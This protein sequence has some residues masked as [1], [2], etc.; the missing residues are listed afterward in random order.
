[1]IHLLVIAAS[2]AVVAKAAASIVTFALAD[3]HD[4]KRSKQEIAALD[5]NVEP[6][7]PNWFV[8]VLARA[9]DDYQMLVRTYIDPILAGR[10][11]NQ[12]LQELVGDKKRNLS[13]QEKRS[14]RRL[15]LGFVAFGL[16]VDVYFTGIQLLPMVVVIGIYN[17]WPW[18]KESYR[19]AFKE[20]RFG[21]IHLI[22]LY[23]A[24]MWI[25]GFFLIGVV[26]AI[27]SGLCQKIQMIT[28]IG[29]REDLIDVLGQKP[30]HVWIE[31][32]GVEVEIP[33]EQLQL[34]DTLILDVGQ[35]IPVDGMILD[36][37]AL[38]DQQR[39]TGESQPVEKSSGDTVLAA[40]VVLGGKL[41]VCVE[42]SGDDT[43]AAKIA[44]V[45]NRTVEYGVDNLRSEFDSVEHTVW[46]MLA[47]GMF[48]LLVG[49][50]VTGAAIL[51]CNYVVGIIPL[52]MIT[53]L[54][55]LSAGSEHGVYPAEL[56][57]WR[58][59]ATMALAEPEEARASPQVTRA[60]KKRIKELER[61]LLRKDRALAET[62]A[63]LVLSKKVAAI[64]NKGEVE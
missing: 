9:D 38:V 37:W 60:D 36:G 6:V 45:L 29:A 50:P 14:N 22:C 16:L 10:A 44:D 11:R 7:N 1:M 39:L 52:R 32:N 18:F 8:M 26:G 28:Q 3:F 27:F 58:L 57:K 20:N 17:L 48:G 23:F 12:H 62:A 2:A 46:P 59:N 51:G 21:I 40:T 63:L 42:K 55:A 19:L 43:T 31:V 56:D 33:F 41:R 24:V 4:E 30:L 47:G 53:L 64:F 15:G 34:G 13:I 5:S 54:N 25:G 49:G 61:E 35:M